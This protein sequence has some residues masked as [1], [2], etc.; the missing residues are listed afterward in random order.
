MS[1][2]PIAILHEDLHAHPAVQAWSGMWA[3]QDVP[4]RVEVLRRLV[5]SE[6]CRLVGAGPGGK[7]VIAKRSP[8]AKISAELIVY[9]RVLPQLSVTTPQY[10]G[11]RPTDGEG[12]EHT[13]DHWIF[14]EDVGSERYSEASP[15][16][17][18][19]TAR[20]V[21]L[22]H[23]AAAGLTA[24][25][26][27]PDGGPRRYLAH[28]C[29]AREK[30]QRRLPGPDLTA[31]DVT[32]LQGVIAILDGLEARWGLID[33]LCEGLPAT[34][35]HGD[36]RPKNVYLRANGHG[37]ACYPIDWETAG[38]GVPA[39]DLTRIDVATYWACA[40]EWQAGLDLDTMQRL[41]SIGRAFCALAGID[42]ES[43]SLRFDSR[44][45][46]SRELAS[47]PVLARRLADAA[48]AVGVEP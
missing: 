29:A 28:L 26:E 23:E 11:S 3:A 1:R 48:R 41:V 2:V 19:L 7:N 36:F 18:T 44:R 25:H 6:V 38:W 40:Q 4:Q 16:H 43:T 30:I 34:L 13:G 17:L 21:A 32:M 20:W 33:G 22:M 42:W 27:L 31:D 37:L 14:L 15:A 5:S 24:V 8:G 10:Y 45:V 46:I 39:A 47:I 35:V 12:E 9:E